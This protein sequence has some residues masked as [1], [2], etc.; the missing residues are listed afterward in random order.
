MGSISTEDISM[1]NTT[2]HVLRY[3]E[4][5]TSSYQHKG[6]EV[7]PRDP[8]G[9]MASPEGSEQMLYPYPFH[10]TQLDMMQQAG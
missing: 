8:K 2:T 9:L 1:F 3:R 5:L 10:P 7:N 6:L 4:Q